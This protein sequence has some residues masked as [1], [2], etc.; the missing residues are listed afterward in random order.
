MQVA[1]IL[2]FRDRSDAIPR[3]LAG[4]DLMMLGLE[5]VEDEVRRAPNARKRP[6]EREQCCSKRSGAR[7]GHRR[8]AHDRLYDLPLRNLESITRLGLRCLLER[9]GHALPDLEVAGLVC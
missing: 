3:D 9:R 8:E 2:I 7:S 1:V 5:L 4:R 6:E